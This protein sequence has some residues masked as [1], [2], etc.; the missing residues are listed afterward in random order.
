MSDVAN[1]A[2]ISFVNRMASHFITT[3][4]SANGEFDSCSTFGTT[5]PKRQRNNIAQL[6]KRIRVRILQSCRQLLRGKFMPR[7]QYS[8]QK[9]L[10]ITEVPVKAAT[11]DAQLLSKQVHP[12]TIDTLIRQHLGCSVNPA[13][14]GQGI[15]QGSFAVRC[16]G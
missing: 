6:F 1:A 3:C 7:A 2:C 4:P 9:V 8:A 16:V 10:A 14:R 11:R 12:N 5:P 15:A 13:F